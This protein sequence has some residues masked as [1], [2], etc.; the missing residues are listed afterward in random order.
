MSHTIVYIGSYAERSAQSIYIYTLDGETGKLAY[1]HSTGGVL[2][3]SFLTVNADQTRLYAVSET[4]QQ[5][6]SVVSYVLDAHKG[7]LTPI[8]EQST[9]GGAPCH[10]AIADKG[11][12]LVLPNYIGG[13]IC[14]YPIQPD[15][16]IGNRAYEVQH[17]GSSINPDRQDTPHPHSTNV[18]PSGKFIFVPDLGLDKIVT[19]EIDREAKQ[20]ILQGETAVKPGSGPRHF[21]FHPQHN[22]A[23]VINEISST[24]IAFTYDPELQTLAAIQTVGTLPADYQ[25]VNTAAEVL[26]H[27]SGQ[28]LYGSNRGHDSIVVFALN[29]TTGQLT[30][31]EHVSTQGK[32]PRNFALTPD[33]AMLLVANQDS[34]NIVSYRID[35]QTGKLTA[36]GESL[37]IPHPVCLKIFN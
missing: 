18:D 10:I 22:Y 17:H 20:L 2:N 26:I 16:S 14:L 33:G 5:P 13:S 28:F 34:S 3:P 25:G 9:N 31:V 27:P 7:Q 24:I 36:T 12:F 37:E 29:P 6:G 23:Y 15:G 11:N 35:Q 32:G 19:Y 30:Y 1:V 8:N 21:V 4:T